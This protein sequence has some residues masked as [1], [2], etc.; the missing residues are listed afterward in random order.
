MNGPTEQ[1]IR[2]YLNRLSLAARTR[3]EPA[4]RQALF[5]HTRARIDA[6]CGGA[7]HATA[8]QVRRT[9][10]GLGDPVALAEKE[11]SRIA[12]R[13]AW[14]EEAPS[15]V[16]RHDAVRAPADA[17]SLVLADPA[18]RSKVSGSQRQI[19]PPPGTP[20]IGQRPFMPPVILPPA[21]ANAQVSSVRPVT[22]AP[23]PLPLPAGPAAPP[24]PV[25]PPGQPEVRSPALLAN[26]TAAPA[27]S[28]DPADRPRPARPASP[29]APRGLPP[30]RGGVPAPRGL[31]PAHSSR[32]Y[33]NEPAPPG[34]A[35]PGEGG[36]AGSN[37][38]SPR[39]PAP[40]PAPADQDNQHRPGSQP[41]DEDEPGVEYSEDRAGIEGAASRLAAI[42]AAAGDAAMRRLRR[43]G[44]AL[45][46]IALRDRRETVSVLLL[47]IGGAIYP[48]VW[49]VGALIAVS[50]RKW[51]L[52]DKWL[53][54]A[55][56]IVAVL[57][58]AALEVTFGAHFS[59]YGR[60]LVEAWVAASRLSR[61][62]AF[63][64]ALFLL[65][66]VHKHGGTRIERLP[67]WSPQRKPG[68]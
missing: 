23:Q 7:A 16:Q 57:I 56:P 5:D 28:D 15:P 14:D 47:G 67:P 51:D 53:G 44:P 12:A 8:E 55:V 32:A 6:E 45:L 42:G 9:L 21:T 24:G 33:G 26:P 50:S 64:S 4:D 48:P 54:L 41:A 68:R 43:L 20:G 30:V 37:R 65:W 62:A 31:P 22:A 58:G 40:R 29:M 63:L 60:Y 13:E 27:A 10:A 1:L 46:A 36:S 2:D 34:G 66:R 59:A 25:A 61:A 19:W 52:R 17:G 38:S 3:L 35:G 49:L 39:P 18:A 11:R